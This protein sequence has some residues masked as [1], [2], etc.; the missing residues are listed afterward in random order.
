MYIGAFNSDILEKLVSNKPTHRT[1]GFKEIDSDKSGTISYEEWEVILQGLKTN[2]LKYFKEQFYLSS[3]VYSGLG[4]EPGEPVNTRVY[5]TSFPNRSCD[6][7][8][9]KRGW[10]EDFVAYCCN[11]HPILRL[12]YSDKINPYK[13]KLASV[14]I[15]GGLITSFAG[16]GVMLGINGDSK[17]Y[18]FLLY[19]QVRYASPPCHYSFICMKGR[20]T[21]P[22]FTA[23]SR[24]FSSRFLRHYSANFATTCLPS[25]ACNTT[26]LLPAR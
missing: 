15:F 11:N 9:L 22:S 21:R 24:F 2:R 3:H 18:G 23:F 12:R 13:P 19:L 17:N 5:E 8:P 20:L 14:E 10:Y 1:K 16:T 4:M 25:R 26:N 7:N 6:C